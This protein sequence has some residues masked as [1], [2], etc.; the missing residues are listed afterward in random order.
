[1]KD[2]LLQ[3]KIKNA[4]LL[5]LMKL[6]GYANAAELSRASGI[7]QSVIGL[8]LN[9]KQVPWSKP[10]NSW[11]QSVLDLAK[12]LQVL[13]EHM[14]PAQHIEQCLPK[15]SIEATVD[16]QALQALS[17]GELEP[18]IEARLLEECN[19]NAVDDALDCLDEREQKILRMHHGIGYEEAYT[20]A[21]IADALGVTTERIRQIQNR[22]I[23]KL[24]HP[25]RSEAL[26]A[27]KELIS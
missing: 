17:A 16:L 2:Y 25:S 3:I 1:M 9:L 4:P 22:A 21:E 23:R 14:F 18:S 12:C 20:L 8:Y 24:K 5:E 7:G 6:Q 11:K 19:V 26:D 10:R 27:L 13:P 15:N